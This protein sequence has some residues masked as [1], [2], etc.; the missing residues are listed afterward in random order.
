MNPQAQKHEKKYTNDH[1]LFEILIHGGMDGGMM[2]CLP[3]CTPY[4]IPIMSRE[5]VVGWLFF[6]GLLGHS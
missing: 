1:A 4:H 3:F 6:F 5:A 2:A